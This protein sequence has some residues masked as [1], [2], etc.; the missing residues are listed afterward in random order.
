MQTVAKEP[1]V[2]EAVAAGPGIWQLRVRRFPHNSGWSLGPK[3]GTAGLLSRGGTDHMENAWYVLAV[4]VDS[5]ISVQN[6]VIGGWQHAALCR[7][8]NLRKVACPLFFLPGNWPLI[9]G[10]CLGPTPDDPPSRSTSPVVSQFCS[11]LVRTR[12][13]PIG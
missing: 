7:F 6:L 1:D 10:S 11:P 8:S 2:R 5:S 3:K 4:Q 12:Q 13:G 9:S